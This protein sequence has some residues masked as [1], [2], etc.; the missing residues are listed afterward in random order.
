MRAWLP[1]MCWPIALGLAGCASAPRAACGAGE[2]AMMVEIL[3]FGTNRP[4]GTVS[5]AD[6][7]AFV[8]EVVTPRFPDGLT[9][10]TASGQWRGASGVVEREGTH[11]LHLLRTDDPARA[12]AVAELVRE[13]ES[14][15][16]QEAVLRE[17]APACIS[18]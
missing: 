6:W 12:A 9:T 11:V 18:F 1:C 13:Y 7:S 2:R 3:Y 4:G 14:R 8:S 5:D 10:W 16:E 17:R 15:F